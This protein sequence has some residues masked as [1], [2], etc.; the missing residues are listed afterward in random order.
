MTLDEEAR[1]PEPST[2]R[3]YA[4]RQCGRGMRTRGIEGWCIHCYQPPPVRCRHCGAVRWESGQ[5]WRYHPDPVPGEQLG[6]CRLC[7]ETRKAEVERR[8]Y[9][10]ARQ[11]ARRLAHK[12]PWAADMTLPGDVFEGFRGEGER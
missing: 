4:C 11:T 10:A 2:R 3:P 9:R 7:E 5:E 12:E 8:Y 1:E 6:A